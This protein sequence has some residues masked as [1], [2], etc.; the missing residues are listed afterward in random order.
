M[1][2]VF[3]QCS[4]GIIL[5]LMIFSS[6]GLQ[7]QKYNFE[8][9]AAKKLYTKLEKAYD[10]YDYGY[11][12]ENE[13]NLLI[14]FE[15]K[16]DTLTALVYSFL[17]ES[18][19]SYAGELNKSLDYYQKELELRGKI[20]ADEDY[21]K[22]DLLSNMATLYDE[23]G[24][25][26]KSED[27]YLQIIK[28]D[29]KQYGKKDEVY[30]ESVLALAIHYTLSSEPEKGIAQL[31]SIDQSVDK[32]T[33]QYPR[34]LVTFGQLYRDQ[35]SLRKAMRYFE[36]ALENFDKQGLNPSFEVATTLNEI[37]NVE[38]DLGKYPKAEETLKEALSMVE[39]MQA[40]G[41]EDVASAFHHNLGEVYRN[42][43]NYEKAVS[44]FNT[45]LNLVKSLYGETSPVVTEEL[46]SLA[47]TYLNEKRYK[48]A[49]ETIQEAIEI[50]N[51]NDNKDNVIYY[52]LLS[53]L[54]GIY[55]ESGKINKSIDVRK[56]SL[57]GYKDILGPQSYDYAYEVHQLGKA[58][59][60]LHDYQNAEKNLLNSLN[61]RKDNFGKFHPD[62]SIS[63]KQMAILKWKQSDINKANG[64]FEETFNTYFK[65]ID[66]FFPTLSEEEKARFYN[67]K[68]KVSFE[69][70]NS[71]AIANLARYPELSS[72]MYNYQLSTK[73]LIMYATAKV[74]KA[75]LESNDEALIKK[76]EEWVSQKEQL[77]K[78]FSSNEYDIETRNAKIDALLESS[79]ELEKQ[80]GKASE[81]FS[82][83]YTKSNYTWKDVQKKLK[84]N[85]AAIEIIRFREFSPDSA[86][87]FTG[88]VNYAALI[89]KKDT[90]DNPELVIL[91]NGDKME[92]RYLANYR[93]A[94]R[95]KVNENYSYNLFWKPI[96]G[97]L[98]D[99]NKVYFSPDG[100]YNQIS[101]YTLRNPESKSFIVDELE[102]QLLTNTKDL[103]AFNKD[104]GAKFD[105]QKAYLFGYPNYNMGIVENNNND[106]E[107]INAAAQK[108]AEDVSLGRGGS[109]GGR[110]SST[111]SGTRSGGL[112]RGVRGNLQ[113][114]VSANS[115]LAL[116]PGT[117]KEVNNI[118][119]LYQKKN[120]TTEIFQ[121]NEALEE[122][123]KGAEKPQT[124]H[125]ATH[126]F[127]LENQ[128]PKE[129][130]V[131]D[132]YVENPLLR[133]G[134][135]FA[136]ANSFLSAGSIDAEGKY[137]EDGILT[138]YEAMNMD[139][140]KTEL[141][142]LSACET[143]LGEVTNGEGVYGL[144]RAFQIAGAESIIMSMWTV[145]DNATQEL[146]NTF[147]EEW[148][149]SGDK[150]QAFNLAQKKIKD[151]WKSPYYWG[152]FIMVGL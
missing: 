64:Y 121:K 99:I 125:I 70:F 68:V 5:L 8:S 9:K 126:G 20:Q 4:I 51:Q 133:S 129:G 48:K 86:G 112:S 93:N 105:Q 82:Q 135:I 142:V 90:E 58:Y 50:I 38:S 29:E 57:T 147:Y 45:S 80:L 114:Y 100:V 6:G 61:I 39:R 138:A 17:A 28:E 71:F 144:Q 84:D 31:K 3:K 18:Y 141:V 37:H 63:T 111:T 146:M 101:I 96:A 81:A 124:L 21:E 35:G 30:L 78:L 34:M 134:L 19:L 128:E 76:Y 23:L 66:A 117:E 149:S 74:R 14:N 26:D 27:L 143:G 55:Q 53:T 72:K 87:W 123:V 65:Q 115:L 36:Q 106:P 52:N 132:K 22:S 13:Q 54:A 104:E 130:E 73:G 85:E 139:L 47:R 67:N 103:V 110:G 12:L 44:S 92:S 145:D 107:K 16:Q 79:N 7:A 89:V 42:L 49:E 62:Y 148:M 140:S 77:S 120:Y 131:V 152:A 118:Q 75:I 97:K 33:D 108:I 46:S 150:K 151:K 10:S 95:Y 88:K 136:G 25:Y 91:E 137:E 43:G 83:T 40:G 122:K 2:N 102:I 59:Q 41:V 94:I 98:N 1:I 113:R 69:Q 56:T 15:Q 24:Y 116:L 32:K 127:F 60:A 109:R 119:S 11:I